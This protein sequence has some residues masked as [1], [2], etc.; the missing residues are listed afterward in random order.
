[1]V[2]ER[3]RRPE[4]NRPFDEALLSGYL[5]GELTQAEEQRVRIHLEDHPEDRALLEEMRTMR[6]ATR[7]T[8]F[9]T[10]EDLQWDERPRGPF[11]R[12]SRGAGWLLVL[13][14]LVG[15]SAYGTWQFLTSPEDL[16]G[17]LLVVGAVGGFALLFV[18][19]LLDR[20]RELKTDRYRR[21]RK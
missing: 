13:I 10:P 2:E 6:D 3:P 15:L 16:L 1:M 19:I 8:R 4:R 5:D 18:S 21:V 12:L 9:E 20:L 7:G 14:W 11:S 17:K